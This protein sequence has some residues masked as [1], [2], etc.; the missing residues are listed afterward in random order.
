MIVRISG[1]GQYELDDNGTHRLEELDAKLTSALHASQEEEFHRQ[2]HSIVTFIR[3]TGKEL[4]HET[5]VPSDIIVPPEDV[6]M[7]EAQRFFTDEGMLHPV[8]A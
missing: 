8:T 4:P 5:V 6:S 7:E 3:E 1:Y 2:L